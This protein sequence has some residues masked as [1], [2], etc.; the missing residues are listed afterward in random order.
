[1]CLRLR[2]N[3]GMAHYQAAVCYE[4]LGLLQQAL[5]EAERALDMAWVSLLL[6]VVEDGREGGRKEEWVVVG[7]G[8]L[9]CDCYLPCIFTHLHAT[10][11]LALGFC[12]YITTLTP[13]HTYTGL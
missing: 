12:C 6:V 4:R 9:T 3:Y 7:G 5:S 1:M 10:D 8:V 11:G 2:P 13:H